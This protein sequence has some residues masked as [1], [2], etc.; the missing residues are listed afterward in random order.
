MLVKYGFIGDVRVRGEILRSLTNGE[1]VA[2]H[3]LTD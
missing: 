3:L 2:S 1:R